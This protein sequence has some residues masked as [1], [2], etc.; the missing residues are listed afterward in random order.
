MEKLN[1]EYIW[2]SENHIT[3]PKDIKKELNLLAKKEICIQ[4]TVSPEKTKGTLQATLSGLE[5]HGEWE[6]VKDPLSE[7]EEGAGYQGCKIE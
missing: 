2:F 1:I 4:M 7:E 3:I 5:Y 6:I